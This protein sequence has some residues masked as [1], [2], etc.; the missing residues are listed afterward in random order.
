M[1]KKFSYTYS[2][3]RN[4]EVGEIRKKYAAAPKTDDKLKHLRELDKKAELP[5]TIAAMITGVIGTL[6]LINGIICII[7]GERIT[8]GV[9]LGIAGIG[10]MGLALPVFYKITAHQRARIA[11]EVL[12]LCDEIENGTADES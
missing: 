11:P 7:R 6:M 12:K 10:F 1:D 9:I 5:G 8:A 2:A 4:A 3:S